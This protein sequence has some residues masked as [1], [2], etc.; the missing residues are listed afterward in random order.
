MKKTVEAKGQAASSQGKPGIPPNGVVAGNGTSKIRADFEGLLEL[1]ESLERSLE[2]H[3]DAYSRSRLKSQGF[4]LLIYVEL[5]AAV[6]VGM[7]RTG[8]GIAVLHNIHLLGADAIVSG[9]FVPSIAF[10]L[11]YT[12][13]SWRYSIDMKHARRAD[14][15]D[16]TEIVELL[17]EIE[18][19]VAREEDWS[20]LERLQIR[21]RLSRFGIGASRRDDEGIVL[22]ASPEG[23]H[24][25]KSR[26]DQEIMKPLR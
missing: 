19:V 26:A 2:R 18:P 21:I 12:Y 7:H 17:R 6:F 11:H 1:A 25:R 20:V 10:T 9:L 24:A 22:E 16:L 5:I 8:L 14:E 23:F 13:Q 4:V 3:S 15:R